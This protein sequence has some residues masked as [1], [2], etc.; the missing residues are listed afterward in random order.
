AADPK[1][2]PDYLQPWETRG[3]LGPAHRLV[4]QADRDLASARAPGRLLVEAG[5]RPVRSR[6]H[7]NHRRRDL[8]VPQVGR[9]PEGNRMPAGRARR[10]RFWCGEELLTG[11]QDRA[12]ADRGTRQWVA[13]WV[14]VAPE[15]EVGVLDLLEAGTRG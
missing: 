8:V 1:R 10:H 11:A 2:Q 13:F 14:P 6:V 7:D 5:M 4:A 15:V 3:Q 12:V 9:P